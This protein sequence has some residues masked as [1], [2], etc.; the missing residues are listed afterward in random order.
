MFDRRRLINLLSHGARRA[1][2]LTLLTAAATALFYFAGHEV[3]DS[4]VFE[5]AAVRNGQVWRWISGHF[6]HCSFEHL[7]WDLVGLVILG[8]VIEGNDRRHALPALFFSCLGVSVW[9]FMGQSGFMSY[10]GLSGALN[11]LL[12]VAVALQ[13]RATKNRIYILAIFMTVFKMIFEFTTHQTIFTDLAAQSVPGAHAA[14]FM[15]GLIY[16]CLFIHGWKRMMC[17]A[18]SPQGIST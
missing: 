17:P 7:F 4:W 8:A 15:A 11:G 16:A 1:P 5:Q 12:V 6:V 9:L 13:M 14:G 3:F 10:C 18:L 2:W